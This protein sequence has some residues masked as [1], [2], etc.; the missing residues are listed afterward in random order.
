MLTFRRSF[1]ELERNQWLE[2]RE[3]TE[4]T[5]LSVSPN[6]LTWGLS[7]NK[8]YTT[9]SLYEVMAFRGMKDVKM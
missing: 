4:N 1:G 3:I 2:L 8:L 5:S 6:S 7:A 9:K